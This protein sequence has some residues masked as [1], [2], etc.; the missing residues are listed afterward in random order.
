MLN[1]LE[2]LVINL[3]RDIE[4][5]KSVSRQQ[6]EFGLRIT[7]VPAVTIDD[8]TEDETRY[9]TKGVRAVWR[10]HMRCMNYLLSSESSFIVIAED[11]FEIRNS[12][13]LSEVLIDSRIYEFDVVQLGWVVPGLRARFSILY[14]D[15]E[16]K[17]FRIVHHFLRVFFPKSSHLKRLRVQ[18]SGRAP[19]GF[20]PDNFLP[21]GQFYLIS[22]KFALSIQELNDPQFLATDDAYMAL[23]KMRNFSFIRSKD[24][25]VRQKSFPKWAGPRFPIS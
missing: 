10:S 25:L 7:R 24:N 13:K 2:I 11:D 23:A 14:T 19:R 15:L 17:V 5:W 16:H 8:V 22:K 1:S 12:K 4:R 18:R 9:V 6:L 21:G 20:I 3:E